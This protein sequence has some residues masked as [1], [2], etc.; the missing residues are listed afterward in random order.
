MASRRLLTCK[1]SISS[2]SELPGRRPM[3]EGKGSSCVA[4]R[5]SS[6]KKTSTKWP[7]WVRIPSYNRTEGPCGNYLC[8]CPSAHQAKEVSGH[9]DEGWRALALHECRMRMLNSRGNLRRGRREKSSL[10]VR[11]RNEETYAPPVF[12]YLDFLRF[13]DPVPASRKSSKD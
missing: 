5:I 7:S 11:Q 13:P 4:A 10:R 1:K 3:Q 9:A 2:M 6:G 8:K 12:Q